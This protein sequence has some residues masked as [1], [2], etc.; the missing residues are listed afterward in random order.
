MKSLCKDP[1]YWDDAL[2]AAEEVR[3][4]VDSDAVRYGHGVFETVLVWHG[5]AVLLEAHQGRLEAAGAELG[6]KAVSLEQGVLGERIRHLA[7]L[8]GL[9][10]GVARCTLFKVGETSPLLVTVD[11]PRPRMGRDSLTV[12]VERGRHTPLALGGIKSNNYLPSLRALR[13]AE[14]SGADEMLF[15]GE[16]GLIGEAATANVFWLDGDRWITPPL[17]TGILPGVQRQ[18]L[19][20][21]I[22]RLGMKVE[23]GPVPLASIGPGSVLMLSNSLLGAVP[24]SRAGEIPLRIDHP[25]VK[26]IRAHWRAFLG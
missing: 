9:G 7:R 18:W 4:P 16:D 25:A 1:V 12:L 20:G 2:C 22:P 15:V 3:L 23:E 17:E 21:E 19:L 6:L 5:E 14:C 11:P 26:K 13:E 24:V 10:T 8:R